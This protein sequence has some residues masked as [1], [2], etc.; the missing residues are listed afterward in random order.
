MNKNK[1]KLTFLLITMLI[2]PNL[3]TKADEICPGGLCWD[4]N[5]EWCSQCE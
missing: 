4:P 3:T 5:L 2:F 1:K